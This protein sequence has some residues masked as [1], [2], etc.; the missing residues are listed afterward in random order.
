MAKI[1]ESP[2]TP[3]PEIEI[4]GESP[5]AKSDPAFEAAA[6]SGCACASLRSAAR[7]ITQL[8]DDALRPTG[9]RAT[10]L[11]LLM[12]A[13]ASGPLSITQLAEAMHTDRT[14][15]TR[16]LRP[17]EKRELVRVTPGDDRRVR[18]VE[19]TDAGRE[20]VAQALPI[21]REVQKE[22]VAGLG[23]SRWSRMRS[24]LDVCASI[25]RGD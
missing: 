20:A 11:G 7:A 15:L 13:S 5:C 9:L 4:S 23:L 24:D 14:T 19:V 6:T 2:N 22:V 25:A 17:L 1:L 8:Y 10:Q 21:W 16:N 3:A 18:T 12:A